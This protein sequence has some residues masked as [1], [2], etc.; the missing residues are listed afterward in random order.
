MYF[1]NI[2]G[3]EDSLELCHQE[4]FTKDEFEKMCKEAPKFSYE[5]GGRNFSSYDTI[6][7][8]EHLVNKYGFKNIE[9]TQRFFINKSNK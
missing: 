4:K 9:F 3:W 5:C 8:S 7:I 6:L 1:Y 2:Y